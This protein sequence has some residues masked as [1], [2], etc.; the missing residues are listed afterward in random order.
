MHEPIRTSLA[1]ALEAIV[2]NITEAAIA[3]RAFFIKN[4]SSNATGSRTSGAKFP[5]ASKK[6]ISRKLYISEEKFFL[7]QN[8]IFHV[9]GVSHVRNHV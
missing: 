8:E 1:C 9:V 3:E 5:N 4:P 6:S 2:A 7:T